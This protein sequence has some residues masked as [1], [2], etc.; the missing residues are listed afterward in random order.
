MHTLFKRVTNQAE[1]MKETLNI[2]MQI[3]DLTLLFLLFYLFMNMFAVV[4]L[5]LPQL[6]LLYF[7]QSV[8]VL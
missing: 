1:T 7:R 3:N 8:A 5:L 2:L 4:L 6:C